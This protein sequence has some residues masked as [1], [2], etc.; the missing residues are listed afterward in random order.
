MKE[1]PSRALHART[2]YRLIRPIEVVAFLLQATN[3]AASLLNDR[4][5]QPQQLVMAGLLVVHLGLAWFCVHHR[6]PLTRGGLWTAVWP[7]TMLVMPL[8]VANSVAPGDYASTGV[9]VQMGGY[10]MITLAVFVF[11][12]WW[13]RFPSRWSRWLAETALVLAVALEPFL[14]LAHMRNWELP[15]A[16]LKSLLVHAIWTVVWYAVG[17]GIKELCRIAVVTESNA[18][19]KSYDEALDGFHTHVETSYL[20]LKAGHD[21]RAVAD[22]LKTA[23]YDRRRLLL[24]ETE[25]VPLAALVKNAVRLFG[26]EL[27]ASYRG[28]GPVNAHRDAAMLL[29][30]GLKDLLKNVVVHGGG[31]AEIEL[32]TRGREAVLVVRDFGPGFDGID[33][34]TENLAQLRERAR[35]AGG[36]LV[37]VPRERGTTMRLTVPLA[38]RR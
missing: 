14:I 24:M 26:D 10:A 7:A 37:Q 31:R 35:R 12:P 32:T 38:S 27:I 22:E 29:E 18:L 3:I 20:R 21:M 5:R 13:Q 16:H 33:A 4:Y 9:G 19:T 25:R 1:L 2:T 30:Q 36:D 34:T 6:G 23:I 11:H 15:T 17:L 8:V 28:P